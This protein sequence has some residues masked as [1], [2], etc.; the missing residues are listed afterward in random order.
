[1]KLVL[2]A[3]LALSACAVHQGDDGG[4]VWDIQTG[5]ALRA[6]ELLASGYPVHQVYFDQLE[7]LGGC[8]AYPGGAETQNGPKIRTRVF[9]DYL[10]AEPEREH[11]GR[12]GRE[13]RVS[14]QYDGNGERRRED[15]RDPLH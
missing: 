8:T 4:Q 5:Q 6:C 11:R 10:P 12:D 7:R 15:R 13:G 3:A 9:T 14:R 1:M 2:L